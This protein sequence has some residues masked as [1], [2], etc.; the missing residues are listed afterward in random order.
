MKYQTFVA[1]IVF[2]FDIKNYPACVVHYMNF[3]NYPY[4]Y[5]KILIRSTTNS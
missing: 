4:F 1:Y 2:I 3:S 5:A